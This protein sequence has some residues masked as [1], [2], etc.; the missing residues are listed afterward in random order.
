M[1]YEFNGKTLNIPD[2]EIERSMKVLKL[3][4]EEAIEMWLDDEGYT[5]NEEVEE[6]THKAKVNKT[7]QHEAKAEN[8]PRKKTERKPKEDPEKSDIIVK[9]AQFFEDYGAELVEITNKTKVVEFNLGGNHY[10]VDLIRQR[11]PKK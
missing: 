5:E 6:M 7:V 3:S 1:K 9:L 11:P 4:K 2:D 8:K 10:K